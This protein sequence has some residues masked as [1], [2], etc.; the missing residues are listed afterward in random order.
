MHLFQDTQLPNTAAGYCVEIERGWEYRIRHIVEVNELVT[1][2]EVA[3]GAG[4]VA[5]YKLEAQAGHALPVE[6]RIFRGRISEAHRRP[7]TSPPTDAS[8]NTGITSR[9]LREIPVAD[10]MKMAREALSE[11]AE[12]RLGVE[13]LWGFLPS[14]EGPPGTRGRARTDDV[15][16]ARLAARYV[17]LVNGGSTR[18]N[19]DMAETSTAEGA[20][21]DRRYF[22]D[23]I[24]EA[25]R[26][27]LL[28]AGSD[29]KA[30]GVLTPK[31]R[32][33]LRQ[34]TE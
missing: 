30:G 13:A 18:P 31:A 27:G 24:H 3:V 29:G 17:A 7:G 12:R 1:W 33:L 19:V 28:S 14:R 16:L 4:W 25:R 22:R 6:L 26:R 32:R 20:P 5:A 21:Y 8:G 34:D 15:F 11:G 2:F 10:H 9:L 23:Q